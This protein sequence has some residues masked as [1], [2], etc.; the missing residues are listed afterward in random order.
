MARIR[1]RKSRARHF[2]PPT[3]LVYLDDRIHPKTPSR[4]SVFYAKAFSPELGILIPQSI[5]RKVTGVAPRSQT[6]ILASNQ[7]RTIHNQPDSGS[8]PR[9]RK[10][11][12]M[13][14]ETAVISD[15]LNDSTTTLDNKGKP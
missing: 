1:S 6:R 7:A 2:T 14:T 13:R 5:V 4:C 15:Y 11:V 3:D 12:L 9:G 8:D 10:R